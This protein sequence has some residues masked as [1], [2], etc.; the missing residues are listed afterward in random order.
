[1]S[2]WSRLL[3]SAVEESGSLTEKTEW[4]PF[5]DHRLGPKNWL[6]ACRGLTMPLRTRQTTTSSL[7]SPMKPPTQFFLSPATLPQPLSAPANVFPFSNETQRLSSFPAT[8]SR[9]PKSF[10]ISNFCEILELF[11]FWVVLLV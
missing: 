11:C 7:S 1:M 6:S 10:R 5:R 2:D 3:L 9:Y 8:P 4:D